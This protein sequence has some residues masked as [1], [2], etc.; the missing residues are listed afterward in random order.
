[1]STYRIL[2]V[3]DEPDM[4]EVAV[5]SLQREPAFEVRACASGREA[6]DLLDR[7][8]PDLVMV[9]VVMPGMDGI[10]L[11]SRL[12]ARPSE[13]PLPVVFISARGL[14]GDADRLKALGATGV[15]AKPFNP[16]TLAATVRRFL[17]PP[18]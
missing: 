16:M 12:R 5:L 11:F 18:R 15:I 7:W 17:P 10:E 14:S 3:D 8:E 6:L 4:R 9:D 2:Y 13:R 1:M